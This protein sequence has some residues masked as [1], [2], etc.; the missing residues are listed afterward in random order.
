MTVA[1][2]CEKHNVELVAI[3]NGTASAKPNVS[4]STCRAVPESDRTASDCSEAGASVYSASEL[5]ARSPGSRRFAAWRGVYRPPFA[6]SAGGA[7]EDG[8]EIYRRRSVSA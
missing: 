3:G 6:G 4:I 7:G 5:A 8:S 1:A 2:L